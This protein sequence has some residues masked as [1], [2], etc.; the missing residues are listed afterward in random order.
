[1]GLKIFTFENFLNFTL[2]WSQ[3]TPF[4]ATVE[5]FNIADRVPCLAKLDVLIT[6]KDYKGNLNTNS[7]S[8][9]IN[10]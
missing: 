4:P 3:V 5:E 10:S 7:K 2:D 6:L 1:M 9:L 8:R